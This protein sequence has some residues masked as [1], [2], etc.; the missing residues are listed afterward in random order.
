MSFQSLAERRQRLTELGGHPGI[1]PWL[2]LD[3]T[4]PSLDIQTAVHRHP[5]SMRQPR[6]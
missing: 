2:V 6:E 3:Q 4:T 5:L 1:C